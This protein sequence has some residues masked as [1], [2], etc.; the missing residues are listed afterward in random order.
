MAEVSPDTQH[1]LNDGQMLYWAKL[2]AFYLEL[3]KVREN[4]EE[5]ELPEGTAPRWYL[6]LLELRL[7]TWRKM[8]MWGAPTD[9]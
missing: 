4:V 8:Q 6:E 1:K 5:L 2:R 9:I 7:S 3:E